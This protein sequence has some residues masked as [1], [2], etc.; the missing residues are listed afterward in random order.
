MLYTVLNGRC[1]YV[2]MQ[3]LWL[4]QAGCNATWKPAASLPNQLLEQ[5][6]DGSVPTARVESVPIYGHVS[7]TLT[8]TKHGHQSLTSDAKRMRQERPSYEDLEG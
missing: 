6:E 2:V 4:G 1:P 5:F 7:S 3:V 8:I